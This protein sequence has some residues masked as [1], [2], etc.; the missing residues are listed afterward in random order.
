MIFDYDLMF[1]DD[2]NGTQQNVSAGH[3]GEAIDLRVSG[4]G[5]GYPGLVAIAF[6]SDTTA[7]A[8]PEIKFSLET[9]ETCDF[10]ESTEIAL[11]WPA[12]KKADLVEGKVL[13]TPLPLIGLQ[14]YVRLNI[15]CDS[16][17]TCMGIRAGFVFDAPLE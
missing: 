15:D 17:I 5:K 2:K 12:F 10:A 7:T 3:L 13:A 4:Q 14:R 11:A 6:S 1:I 9:S 8:D 16:P